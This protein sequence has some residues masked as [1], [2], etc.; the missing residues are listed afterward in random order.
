MAIFRGWGILVIILPV[1]AILIAAFAVPEPDK[2][3]VAA[4]GCGVTGLIL[5]FVGRWLNGRI[6][7]EPDAY[8]PKGVE[9]IFEDG[10]VGLVKNLEFKEALFGRRRGHSL[11][12][13]K[14]EFWCIFG[15]LLGGLFLLVKP[16]DRGW[17]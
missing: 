8:Q 6:T 17:F 11:F 13:V 1:A 5:W 9:K 16:F 15:F 14:L 12:W 7:A 10:F 4:I 3:L 2:D